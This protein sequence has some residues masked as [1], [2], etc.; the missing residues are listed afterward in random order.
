LANHY[1]QRA[2]RKVRFA[3]WISL[4]NLERG[5]SGRSSGSNF[6][7]TD[8]Y[9]ENDFDACCK[10]PQKTRRGAHAHARFEPDHGVPTDHYSPRGKKSW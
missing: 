6:P 8:V 3:G 2:I 7:S 5:T 1:I 9:A 10:A 4:S